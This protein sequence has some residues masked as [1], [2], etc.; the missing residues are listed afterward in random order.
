MGYFIRFGFSHPAALGNDNLF[1]L[2]RIFFIEIVIPVLILKSSGM[3]ALKQLNLNTLRT[4][5]VANSTLFF[6]DIN[7]GLFDFTSLY[8]FEFL[9]G[10]IAG[11]GGFSISIPSTLVFLLFIVTFVYL[12]QILGELILG[13]KMLFSALPKG[14]TLIIVLILLATF[15]FLFINKL[16]WKG[17]LNNNPL[18]W[19][20][21]SVFSFTLFK[22]SNWLYNIILLN[23]LFSVIGLLIT[24]I[25]RIFQTNLLTS[26]VLK[27]KSKIKKR[28]LQLFDFISL[29]PSG[30]QPYLRK[31]VKYIFRCSRSSG[32]IILE[33]LLLVFVGYMH[34]TK[35]ASYTRFYFPAGFVITSSVVTWDFFLGNQWG[36]EKK[37]FGY[38][39]FSNVD[40]NNIILSKNVSF[41][42][43]RLPSVLLIS[44]VMCFFFSFKY[45]PV[46][47]LL[48]LIA[49]VTLLTFTNV[50]SVKNPFPVE[51][52]ESSFSKRQPHSFTWIGMIGLVIYMLLPASLLF[53][54]YKLGTGIII[55]SIM[56]SILAIL[57]IFYKNITEHASTLL[58]K[59]K[60][61]IYKKLIKI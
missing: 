13:I 28:K 22:E 41:L 38:Y 2:S 21:N 42:L 57:L 48:Y 29:F 56:L 14:R 54:L 7:T 11:A 37:G 44:I 32:A 47:I 24:I 61:T 53:T 15:Y 4:Y 26:H 39:L 60:E 34:F 59:Q 35:S 25:T 18:T 45:F 20:V 19:S 30:L 40:F 17:V 31:D 27:K 58:I 55:Y 9:I 43:V 12:I 52:K 50:V 5:P 10:L 33:L 23:V 16:S 8:L 51:L 3:R 1:H 36:Y 46:M 6:F 49:N